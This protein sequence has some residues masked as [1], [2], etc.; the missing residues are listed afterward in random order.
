MKDLLFTACL[1]L[2][3]CPL[4]L[5]VTPDNGGNPSPD[6]QP[7]GW[8]A[9]DNHRGTWAIASSCLS[10][11]FACTWSVQHLNVGARRDGKWTPWL[12]SVKWM[13]ITILFPELIVLHAIFEFSMALQ[14]L[15][16]MERSEK[17]V[18]LPWWLPPSKQRKSQP[19]GNGSGDSKWTLT[20]CFFA[21]MGG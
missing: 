7:V 5:A 20:H 8:Q 12:R 4:V 14:A 10:T 13:I 15:R 3:F 1:L 17:D 21:N 6:D 16:Q 9:G 18:K 19:S 2:D 11:I